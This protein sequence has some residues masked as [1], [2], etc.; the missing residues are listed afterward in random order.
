MAFTH[1][2][3]NACSVLP[4]LSSTGPTRL[5][6]VFLP[7]PPEALPHIPPGHFMAVFLL[8]PRAL[9]SHFCPSSCY[10]VPESFL[11]CFFSGR[12]GGA[13][14]GQ[15]AECSA[16]ACS[17]MVLDETNGHLK[18]PHLSLSPP[19]F[20]QQCF[21]AVLNLCPLWVSI[22]SSRQGVHSYSRECA[23]DRGSS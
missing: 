12:D 18:C 1:L 23:A 7:A 10:I 14:Q 13:A 17:Q 11:Y 5:S 19:A 2:F 20:C 9:C 3:S 6:P 21:P 16:A 22:K 4:S 15:G 8:A